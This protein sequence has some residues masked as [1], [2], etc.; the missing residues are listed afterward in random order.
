MHLHG[1]PCNAGS[2]IAVLYANIL[3]LRAWD[4]LID[5]EG[6]KVTIASHGLFSSCSNLHVLGVIS[7]NLGDLATLF[8]RISLERCNKRL[9]NTKWVLTRVFEAP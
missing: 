4:I 1:D 8:D 9:G 6:K 2:I 3:T 7:V 5:G